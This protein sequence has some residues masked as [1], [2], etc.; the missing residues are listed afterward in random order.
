[1]FIILGV[2]CT[3]YWA[4]KCVYQGQQWL[5][6]HC[7]ISQQLCTWFVFCCGQVHF[8]HIL[9]GYFTGMRWIRSMDH[10]IATVPVKQPWRIWVNNSH[11]STTKNYI[12]TTTSHNQTLWLSKEGF[13]YLLNK[14]S[15]CLWL[16]T[17]WRS[18][19]ATMMHQTL[20]THYNDV[21]MDTMASQITSLTIVFLTVIQT[22]IKGNTKA[23][24]HIPG[25]FPAQRTSNAENVSIWWRHHVMNQTMHTYETL[26]TSQEYGNLIAVPLLSGGGSRGVLLY[27]PVRR[28]CA[29]L[30]EAWSA[31]AE[32]T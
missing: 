30:F 25:E 4:Q 15:N 21:I 12:I 20:C 5:H 17:P 3:G 29:M 18:Y 19:D 16:E 9:Q 22:Q 32:F 24:R 7:I 31:S 1:M 6:F 14:Q 26:R 23:L 13:G 2:Y 10:K 8:T 28:G 27:K 11:E